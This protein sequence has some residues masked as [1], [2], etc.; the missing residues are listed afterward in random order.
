MSAEETIRVLIA[1][2]NPS[3]VA[4]LLRLLEP[5]P[6]EPVQAEAVGLDR[7]K[8]P[9]TG[10]DYQEIAERKAV[11]F[12]K[13]SGLLSIASDGGVEIPVLQGRWDGLKSRRF[14]GPG[15]EDR[16]EKLLTMLRGVPP[17]SRTVR[18]HEAVALALPDGAIVASGQSAGP[19][20]RLSE[21]ADP[22]RR[23]GFWLP[24]LWLYP[25]RW[26][27]EWDL[28]DKERARLRTAWDGVADDLKPELKAFFGGPE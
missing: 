17:A 4:A 12:A 20:G 11:T 1:T 23:E 2:S 3:K 10:G 15:D 16:I 18:F 7:F 27:T 5:Y 25:P 8:I 24:S 6:V 21:A 13:K 14:A 19:I 9:E 28:T 22:R 26:V